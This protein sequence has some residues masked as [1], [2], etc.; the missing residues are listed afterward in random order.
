M[1]RWLILALAA[2]SLSACAPVV[3]QAWT[4]PAAFAGPRL[5]PDAFISFDGAKLGLQQ[6]LPEAEPWAVIVGVHGMDDYANAFDLAGPYW[7][8][9]GV[10]VIAYDQRGF[11][12]SPQR[13]VWGGDALYTRDLKT[14]VTL[15]R[16]RYPHAIVAVAAE[17]M[18]GSV[19]IEAF[20]SAQ[21]P[22]ADRLV[23]ISPGVWGW[24]SQPLP[25][26]TT[27]W[28]A[29]HLDPS[30]QVNPPDFVT[31]HIY[32]SDNID[33]LRRMG[34]DP[35]ESWGARADALYGLVALM[36]RASRD[37]GRIRTPVLYLA[38]A[39]D[40]IIPV[41]AHERAARGLTGDERSAFYANGWHLLIVDKERD[42]VFRDIESFIRDPDAPL[43]S[44]APR[45]P[46][47]GGR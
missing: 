36:E 42:L 15:V 40:Q 45:V 21:P 41:P 26:K 13:G 37:V 28:L 32:P 19:A 5:E 38:G 10:A 25:Y 7:A 33:E 12:R 18:G 1:R 35:L 16:A 11:G 23:L 44:G 14:I 47:A 8:K 3:Q 2:L 20:A 4:P 43:P 24:S 22:A 31:E 46:G 39:H 6:W 29:A 30:M 17:S 27:L 9:D 34:R